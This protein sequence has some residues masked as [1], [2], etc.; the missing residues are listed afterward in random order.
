[1]K[2]DTA[3]IRNWFGYSRRERRASFILLILIVFIISVRF[4]F[5]EKNLSIENI[6]VKLTYDMNSSVIMDTII[7]Q[8]AELKRTGRIKIQN[9]KVYVVDINRCDTSELIRLYGIGS[10]LSVRIIK[11]RNLLGGF[12]SV[13]QLREVYGLSVE[14]YDRIK[15]QIFVDT[16]MI[17]TINVNSASYKNLIR[18]PY[19]DKNEVASILKYRDFKGGVSGLY[20]LVDNKLITEEKALKVRSYLRFE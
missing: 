16:M 3:P 1:M 15:D 5:P 6:P 18:F 9:K 4:L 13:N 2:F 12:S 11:Y 17:S 14:T 8:K 19:F 7:S 20:E 10:V